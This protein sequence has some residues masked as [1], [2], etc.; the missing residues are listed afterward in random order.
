MA[1]TLL[2]VYADI[3]RKVGLDP[4]ITAFSETD[5]SNDVVQDIY[6]AYR[7]LRRKLQKENLD[8]F[9]S[10]SLA[11]VAGT[12]LYNLASG[13]TPYG[14]YTWS[15]ENETD[16]DVFLKP[17]TL[18]YIKQ[19]FHKWDE[20][21]DQPQYYYFEGGQIGFYPIPDGV[22]TIKYDY[23]QEITEDTATTATFLVPD[24][25]LDFVKKYAQYLYETRKGFG[26]PEATLFFANE[27]LS[28][29][30]VQHWRENP[31]Y[32]YVEGMV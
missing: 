16:D 28:D 18:A 26:D 10:G 6:E 32:L 5:E 9:A 7:Y 29:V 23:N 4:T 11:T 21:Q 12:R 20:E 1:E 3:A 2:Q 8:F 22:R 31:T 14:V 24:D 17:A 15:V 25:H 19:T 13:A 30:Q 27:I